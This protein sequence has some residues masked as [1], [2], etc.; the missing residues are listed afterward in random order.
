M[1]DP[2]LPV[3]IET[4]EY[5]NNGTVI[6]YPQ[7]VEHS[8]LHVEHKINHQIEQA[9]FQLAT[10]QKKQQGFDT[11]DQ[12]IGLYEIK[13]NERNVFSL[14]LTNYAIHAQA[15]HGLTLMN[16][17]NFNMSSGKNWRLSDQFIPGSDYETQLTM[18]VNEQ[19]G[20]RD[21]PVFDDPITISSDQDYY[22]ADKAIVLFYQLYDISPYYVGLPMFPISVYDI[23]ELLA[24]DSLLSRMLR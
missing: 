6:Y 18:L 10:A 11:F 23:E 8:D 9:A 4:H 12:M 13:T 22:I 15:A 5:R 16:G 2:L 1:M 14:T 3:A 7:I 17:L 19:I 24:D 21:F 20:N